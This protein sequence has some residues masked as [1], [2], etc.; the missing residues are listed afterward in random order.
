MKKYHI[1][2]KGDVKPCN[3]TQR[4]CRFGGDDTHYSN[5]EEALKVAEKQNESDNN[6]QP[7]TIKKDTKNSHKKKVYN[8]RLNV[9]YT[10]NLDNEEGYFNELV[11][12]GKVDYTKLDNKNHRELGF[13][14]HESNSSGNAKII[15]KKSFMSQSGIFKLGEKEAKL[16]S[17]EW[18]AVNEIS[19]DSYEWINGALYSDNPH[20]LLEDNGVSPK[21]LDELT[22]NIDSALSKGPKQ[23]RTL[24]RGVRKD[25]RV[26]TSDN[27]KVAVSEWV[28]NN[29]KVGEEIVFDG[30]QSAS[31]NPD[32][33]M[34]Y[35]GGAEL[36]MVGSLRKKGLASDGLLYEIITPEGLN[37]SSISDFPE[38]QEVLLPRKSRYV[39]VGVE[40]ANVICDKK[41]VADTTV[42]RLMAMNSKGEI[43]DGSNS[44]ELEETVYG[45]SE[46]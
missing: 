3:A 28:E 25:S 22:K 39:V 17:E 9:E 42:V 43:L 1:N 14:E 18:D 27:K 38:E 33:A 15:K 24:Y 19:T 29:L 37:I 23:Q 2:S 34:D 11:V 26:F 13:L 36:S 32:V 12:S 31:P 35:A 40:K 30:Y 5:F 21:F 8:S 6:T 44:D 20:D 10:K 7:M 4:V 46:E 45:E 16:T 41:G